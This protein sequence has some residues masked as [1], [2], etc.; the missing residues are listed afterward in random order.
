MVNVGTWHCLVCLD[1]RLKYM[2]CDHLFSWNVH[3]LKILKY[4]FQL[5]Q[6]TLGQFSRVVIKKQ[7]SFIDKAIRLKGSNGRKRFY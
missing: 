3:H 1:S 2:S 6:L 5:L 7:V 4:Q